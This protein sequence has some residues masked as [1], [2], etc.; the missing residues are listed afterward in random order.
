MKIRTSSGK[1]YTKYQK[2]PNTNS[3]A[4]YSKISGTQAHII[5]KLLTAT[6]MLRHKK[7]DKE[8]TYRQL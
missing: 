6:F 5:N 2:N 4:G 8:L 1:T 7:L 3:A